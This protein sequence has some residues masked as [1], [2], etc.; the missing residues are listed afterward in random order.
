MIQLTSYLCL[1]SGPATS[2][3]KAGDTSSPNRP[4]DASPSPL[5][6]LQP[7]QTEPFPRCNNISRSLEKCV[8]LVAL[9]CPRPQAPPAPELCDASCENRLQDA[10]QALVRRPQLTEPKVLTSARTNPAES[11]KMRHKHRPPATG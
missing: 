1:Y 8:T 7:T 6:P 11:R 2:Y 10:S 3:L 9:A 5:A 4:Q